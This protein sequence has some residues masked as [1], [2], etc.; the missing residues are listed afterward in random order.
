MRLFK[1]AVVATLA[2]GLA[3]CGQAPEG[4]HRKE[5]HAL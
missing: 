1:I 4:D 5:L 3:A 2:A